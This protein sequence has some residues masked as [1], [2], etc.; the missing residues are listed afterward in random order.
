MIELLLSYTPPNP[1]YLRLHDPEPAYQ[2]CQEMEHEL[3][4][5]VEFDIISQEQSDELIM[6][7]L[8]NYSTGPNPH[9]QTPVSL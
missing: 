6:R 9:Y 7:C 1:D 3:N 8:I 5:G 4:Q 2:I